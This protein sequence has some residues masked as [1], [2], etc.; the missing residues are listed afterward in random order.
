MQY[1]PTR[2]PADQVIKDWIEE[3]ANRYLEAELRGIR[4]TLYA[5]APNAATTHRHDYLHARS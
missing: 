3:P 4:R 5:D 1:W 2:G